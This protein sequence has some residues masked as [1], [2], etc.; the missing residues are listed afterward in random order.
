MGEMKKSQQ[1]EIALPEDESSFK[2]TVI[3]SADGAKLILK[4]DIFAKNEC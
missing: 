3:S 1:Q 4:L 2:G